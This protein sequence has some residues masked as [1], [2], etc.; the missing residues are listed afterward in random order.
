MSSSVHTW[1]QT[2]TPVSYEWSQQSVE[3]S[4]FSCHSDFMCNQFG[5]FY[6]FCVFRGSEFWVE[7]NL[8]MFESWNLLNSKFSGSKIAEMALIELRE[9]RKMTLHKM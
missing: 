2:K 7:E 1:R 9:P 4:G 8:A 5:C 3:I 6:H